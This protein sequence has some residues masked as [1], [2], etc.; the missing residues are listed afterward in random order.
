MK[1]LV[2]RIIKETTVK[3]WELSSPLNS[4]QDLVNQREYCVNE[5]FE[6]IEIMDDY[7][8]KESLEMIEDYDLKIT[9][10]GTDLISIYLA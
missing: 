5:L 2:N 4:F 1:N 6:N 3:I 8:I 9:K 7:I 10:W